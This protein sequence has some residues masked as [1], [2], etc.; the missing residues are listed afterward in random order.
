[1][2]VDYAYKYILWQMNKNQ[3]GSVSATEFGYLY[4]SEQLAFT[5]DLLGAWQRNN[6]SKQGNLT[7]LIENQ[8]ILNKLAPCTLEVLLEFVNGYAKAPI[9]Y[10]YNLGLL[11]NGHKMF[12]LTKDQLYNLE[13]DVIDTPSIANN[14]YYFTDLYSS[15]YSAKRERYFYS[16]PQ[17][18][19]R[20]KLWYITKPI[21]VVWAFTI[22]S[23]RQVY[24]EIDSV[25]PIWD[26]IT[27]QEICNRCLKKLGVHFKDGDFV[28]YGNSVIQ[29]AN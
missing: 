11:R 18:S 13:K 27:A 26:D 29:T 22:V 12:Y 6:N 24:N 8:T 5:N 17:F 23:G 20:G 25:D 3:A 15:I 2:N 10:L 1:M 14:I 19:G 4:N 9:D 21:D 28:N 16:Y 7:G